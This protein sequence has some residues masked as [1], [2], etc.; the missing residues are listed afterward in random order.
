MPASRCQAHS[1]FSFFNLIFCI[2]DLDVVPTA[3]SVMGSYPPCKIRANTDIVHNQFG[4]DLS[5]NL[6]TN[7]RCANGHQNKF[8]R[9]VEARSA[10]TSPGR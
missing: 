2:F 9:T 1:N 5:G 3:P 10:T 8:G 7:W 6:K 4:V